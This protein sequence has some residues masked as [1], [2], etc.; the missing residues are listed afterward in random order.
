MKSIDKIGRGNRWIKGDLYCLFFAL[1]YCTLFFG[2]SKKSSAA[3]FCPN[4]LRGNGDLFRCLV[5][6][7][8]EA[9][10]FAMWSCNST[11]SRFGFMKSWPT[12]L[13]RKNRR[14]ALSAR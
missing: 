2:N 10:F 1:L 13:W 14:I 7:E 6:V 4:V 12:V 11:S 3:N 9:P 8:A 5:L